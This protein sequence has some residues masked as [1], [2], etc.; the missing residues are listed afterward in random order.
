MD[1]SLVAKY[2]ELER[3][4]FWWR[5][6]RDLVVRLVS[7][8][9]FEFPA[10][11]DVGCG[12]GVTARTLAESGS[13]VVG[14]DLDPEMPLVPGERFQYL[15]GD[16]LELSSDLGEF[17]LV[18]ALDAVEH[19]ED[20]R[21]V[22]RAMYTNLRPGGVAI[23]TVPA[24]SWLWSSHD[25]ENRHFRRYTRN[26]L[27]RAMS[28]AGFI[29]DRVGY[30]F[31]GL[32]A[33]KAAVSLIEGKGSRAVAIAEV[34]NSAINRVAGSYFRFETGLASRFRNF[35]PFGTSVLAV[36]SKPLESDPASG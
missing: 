13:S 14:V 24:Y 36:A 10:V 8:L 35:L 23:V 16:F 25:T 9:P 11:L 7:G 4:H 22:L 19:F 1:E 18:L 29:P 5:T 28:D 27:A 26:R 15:C 17:D 2:P 21:A 3:S 6:R 20:E 31:G 32:L 34:P 12:S 30:L 33:P